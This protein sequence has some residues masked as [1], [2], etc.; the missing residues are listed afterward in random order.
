MDVEP[1][2]KVEV[3]AEQIAIITKIAQEIGPATAN[4]L[5]NLYDANELANEA[6]MRMLD[7]APRYN[8]DR[9]CSFK[10]Y[11]AMHAHFGIQDYMR[12]RSR[13]SRT[14]L[15][16][17]IAADP[18]F[19][20]SLQSIDAVKAPANYKKTDLA[21][22]LADRSVAGFYYVDLRDQVEEILAGLNPREREIMRLYH[23]HDVTMKE[24]GRMMD[25]S[26]SRVSQIMSSLLVRLRERYR[27]RERQ[28]QG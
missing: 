5:G 8:P 17:R 12:R 28:Q 25:L 20:E 27:I 13:F 11:M 9:N 16:K 23:L 1:E 3:T 4:K 18:N 15:K 24:I 22:E 19:T 2:Q 21:S 7:Y 14:E 6:Y 10:S 26:E